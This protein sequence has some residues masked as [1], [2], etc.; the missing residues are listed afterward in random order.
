MIVIT[1]L[2]TVTAFFLAVTQVSIDLLPMV[3]L[4]LPLSI[5]VTDL[6]MRCVRIYFLKGE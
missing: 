2:I 4:A 6:L 3:L 5:Y 1:L